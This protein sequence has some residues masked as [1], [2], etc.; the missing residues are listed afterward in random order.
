MLRELAEALEAL[1]AERPLHPHPGRPALERRRHPG[2]AGVRGAAA[3][4]G[5]APGPGHLSS[6]GGAGGAH[7][8]YPVTRELLVHGQG[9]ELVLGALSVAEVAAYVTQRFG[10]GALAAALAPVLHQRT[11]GNPLFLVT[12]VADLV[13]RGVLREGPPAGNCTA[14]WTPPRWACRRRAT[15][16]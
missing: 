12:M 11:Q 3:G 15:A 8:L 4:P 7:P 10:A 16:D 1:T 5:A 9:A 13:Q 14:A 6:G 2:V